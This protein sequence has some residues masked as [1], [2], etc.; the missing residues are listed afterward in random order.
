MAAPT[1]IDLSPWAA[2]V[3][4]AGA[5]FGPIA[6]QYIGAYALILMG[7]FAGLLYGLFTRSPESKMPV[8]AYAAFTFIVC[9]AVTVPTSQAAARYIPFAYTAL[10]FPVSALIPAL[11]DQWGTFGQW[12]VSRWQARGTNQ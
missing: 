2:A 6:A 8:W 4:A 12:V 1:E 9:A 5:V 7:W 11:P 3:A 10:L